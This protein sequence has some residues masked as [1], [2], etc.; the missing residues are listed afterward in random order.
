M[1]EVKLAVVGIGGVG[2][3]AL[4]IQY[5]QGEFLSYYDPTIEDSY[6]KEDT[7]NNE[8]FFIDILDTAGQEEFSA[9]RDNYMRN[10]DGFLLVYSIVDSLSFEEV[11]RFI[12]QITRVK[13]RENIPFVLV[14][15]KSDLESERT[16]P[17]SQGQSFAENLKIPFFEASAK[18][19]SN[20]KE[21]F[22]EL[23]QITNTFLQDKKAKKQKTEGKKSSGNK[24]KCSLL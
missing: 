10:R 8:T 17:T 16:V 19:G 3:S 24:K 12:S 4:S 5:L 13:E 23:V 21:C 11:E 2:K 1:T 14:G 22:R 20:V 6:R 7:I 15:N 18:T 9:L